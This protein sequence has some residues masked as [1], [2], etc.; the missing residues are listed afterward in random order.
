[1]VASI[2]PSTHLHSPSLYVAISIHFL[3]LIDRFQG[4][5]LLVLIAKTQPN[6]TRW[7]AHASTYNLILQILCISLSFIFT[8]LIALRLHTLRGTVEKVMG[9]LQASFYTSGT[10][11]FVESGAFLTLWSFCYMVTLA[12]NSWAQDIFLKPYP[13]IV[14]S[15]YCPPTKLLRFADTPLTDNN[16]HTHR[17]QDGPR[18]RM[19]LGHHCCHREWCAG[20]EGVLY[21]EHCFTP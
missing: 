2:H 12:S 4:M 21:T 7:A 8:I 16:V 5:S 13:Y 19:D 3:S 6:S 17:T 9:K 20:M 14:V 15:C 1:M 18:S 11:I 10:T